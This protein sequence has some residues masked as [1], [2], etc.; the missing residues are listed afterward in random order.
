MYTVV[1]N[2]F[3]DMEIWLKLNIRNRFC[4]SLNSTL[5]IAR[6]IFHAV[7]LLQ[8]LRHG[9][10]CKFSRIESRGETNVSP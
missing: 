9:Q 8:M 7:G 3:G 1:K 2:S 10:Y 4:V 6:P 5:K